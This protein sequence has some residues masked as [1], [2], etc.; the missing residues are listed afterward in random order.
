[1]FAVVLL[2]LCAS[3]Q[4]VPAPA[5]GPGPAGEEEGRDEFRLFSNVKKDIVTRC[6][7]RPSDCDVIW[8]AL[9]ALGQGLDPALAALIP[10]ARAGASAEEAGSVYRDA[11]LAIH[12]APGCRQSLKSLVEDSVKAYCLTLD[13]YSHYDDAETWERAQTL[14]APE[15]VGI[16]ITLLHDR[17][18][19]L[20]CDPV[21]GG[22]ADRLG[23]DLGDRLLAIGPHAT[24]G[25]TPMM[26]RNWMYE[27]GLEKIQIRVRHR[28]GQEETLMAPMGRV[29]PKPVAVEQTETGVSIIRLR[30]ISKRAADDFRAAMRSVGP[31]RELT[32]DLRGNPG[33]E[34]TDAVA[35]ASVFLPAGTLIGRLETVE[36]AERLASENKTPY[37]PAK[38]TILQDRYTGSA[39]ELII[40]ALEAYRPLRVRTLGEKT[41]GKGVTQR[42]VKVSGTDSAGEGKIRAGILTITDSR[43][44]GPHDEVWDEKGL[45]P[46]G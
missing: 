39:A 37:V 14:N 15:Y 6:I 26:V 10:P 24:R 9:A 16:G 38:L 30:N 29:A 13:R 11:L 42:Q 3:A 12:R 36:S 2:A 7:Y 44:Y 45:A 17:G 1:M 4:A 19:D 43:I 22:P 28:D 20:I 8:G 33:G 5:P 27:A 31:G 35:M 21:R 34:V 32:L 23:V 18:E 41:F 40:V 25:A 46:S